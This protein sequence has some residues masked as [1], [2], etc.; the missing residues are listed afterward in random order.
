MIFVCDAAQQDQADG[1][2][3]L[4][5]PWS[6]VMLPPGARFPFRHVACWVYFQLTGGVGAFDVAVEMRQVQDDGTRRSVG[7][8][9]TVEMDFPG[10]SQLLAFDMALR[11]RRVPFR[12]PGLYEFCV[13]ADSAVLAG[14]AAEVRVLDRR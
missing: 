4:T 10:G 13:T 1:K 14:Q 3:V 7:W 9:P 2:W 12:E 6:V 5:N 11:L 8:S